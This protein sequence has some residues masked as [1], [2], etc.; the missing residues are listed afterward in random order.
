MVPPRRRW[1]AAAA[2]PLLLAACGGSGDDTP[3]GGASYLPLAEGHR[4]FYDDG[5][6]VLIARAIASDATAPW[7]WVD[8][9]GGVSTG[10][11][12]QSDAAG[13]RFSEPAG[14]S[15]GY[16]GFTQTALRTP[17]TA[18]DRYPSMR[19][20]WRLSDVDLDGTLDDTVVSS[21]AEVVA[22]E[23]VTTPAGRFAD[24]V[25]VRFSKW[26]GTVFQPSGRREVQRTS[27]IDEW[28]AP[29]IGLVKQTTVEMSGELVETRERQL[30]GYRLGSR[31]GGVPR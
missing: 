4:W 1:F 15:A 6:D 22:F 14:G 28:Y 5:S 27:T 24:T 20:V 31:S 12:V 8:T 23:T 19:L 18:G 25:H 10:Q 7:V 26:F 13:V 11:Y 3:D 21:D 30:A 9:R 29:G 17:V 2:A 16:P